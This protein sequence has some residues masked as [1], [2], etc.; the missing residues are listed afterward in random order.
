MNHGSLSSLFSASTSISAVCFSIFSSIFSRSSLRV[1]CNGGMLLSVTFAA[2][3]WRRYMWW[4]IMKIY[5]D[6]SGD[7][8]ASFLSSVPKDFK[9]FSNNYFLQN[10]PRGSAIILFESI[11]ISLYSVLLPQL[12]S[13]VS[14]PWIISVTTL[15]PRGFIPRH[16]QINIRNLWFRFF[17]KILMEKIWFR[18]P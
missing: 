12:I 10:Q 1:L 5:P 4:L 11:S 3:S 8:T 9:Q 6:S 7:F 13:D 15:R 16:T 14:Q 17:F 18:L 2:W